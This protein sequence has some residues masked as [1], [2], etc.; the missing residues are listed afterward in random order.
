LEG[1]EILELTSQK[2]TGVLKKLP[3]IEVIKTK[4]PHKFQL[5]NK[6]DGPQKTLFD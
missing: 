3:Q 5:K 1:K 6:F 4:K 2:L